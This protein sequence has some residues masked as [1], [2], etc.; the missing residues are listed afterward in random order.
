MGT[1]RWRGLGA[2][3]PCHAIIEL[4]AMR[5]TFTDGEWLSQALAAAWPTH[6]PRGEARREHENDRGVWIR[7]R[8]RH[9]AIPFAQYFERLEEIALAD[10]LDA[11]TD[12]DKSLEELYEGTLVLPEEG[13]S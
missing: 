12:D 11:M 2:V 5:T 10:A 7:G 1:H 13:G 9:H 8:A 6:A 4:V 3:D